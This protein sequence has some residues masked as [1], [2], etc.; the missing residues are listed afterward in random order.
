MTGKLIDGADTL[1][2][3]DGEAATLVKP[4]A[5]RTDQ[6]AL[7]LESLF[8]EEPLANPIA[9]TAA[10]IGQGLSLVY[11]VTI[12]ENAAERTEQI[13]AAVR[14]QAADPAFLAQLGDALKG[15]DQ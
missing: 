2:R 8:P 11:T 12:E 13:L 5:A 9:S 1:S 3:F 15:V 14:Q 7:S 6:I 10:V 4:D